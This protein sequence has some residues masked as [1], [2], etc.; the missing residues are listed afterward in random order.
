MRLQWILVVVVVV[1]TDSRVYIMSTKVLHHLDHGSPVQSMLE[2]TRKRESIY[3]VLLENKG[4]F[5]SIVLNLCIP[6]TCVTKTYTE[7]FFIG[8][9]AI[10]EISTHI[11]M[12]TYA[13]EHAW[14]FRVIF[15][16][17]VSLNRRSRSNSRHNKSLR[18]WNS[19][20][21][22]VWPCEICNLIEASLGTWQLR[23]RNLRMLKFICDVA[24]CA[25]TVSK[26]MLDLQILEYVLLVFHGSS[27]V[28]LQRKLNCRSTN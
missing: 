25:K 7:I 22:S 28:A 27:I 21:L 24:M 8:Y 14:I 4:S 10:F 9:F 11:H 18:F 26:F 16:I 1:R 2:R 15:K 13:R 6:G 20:V 17:L 12:H 5:T 3:S 19:I 23:S